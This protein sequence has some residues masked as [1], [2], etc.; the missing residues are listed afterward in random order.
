M[1]YSH[2]VLY[3]GMN[4]D[5]KI[6]LI[7]PPYEITD[8]PIAE[9]LALWDGVAL[10]VSKTPVSKNAFWIYSWIDQVIAI[11][12]CAIAVLLIVKWPRLSRNPTARVI[13][14]LLFSFLTAII[15]HWIADEGIARNPSAC[16]LVAGGHFKPDLS[17]LSTV[18]LKE[19]LATK[20]VQLIDARGPEAFQIFHL[21]GAINLPIYAGLAER[22][23]VYSQLP[24]DRKIVVYCNNIDCPWAATIASDLALRGNLDFSLYPGGVEEWVKNLKQQ[25]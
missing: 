24:H 15:Y 8:L 11:F 14:I 4:S 22:S 17:K 20:S 16:G 7:D 18:E 10:A 3:V 9:L 12:I 21:P 6:R 13:A 25:K 1:S 23:A 19:L 2:W 5:N